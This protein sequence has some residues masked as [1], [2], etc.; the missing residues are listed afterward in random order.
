MRAFGPVRRG[1]APRP[2][3]GAAPAQL[4]GARARATPRRRAPGRWE[5][6][7]LER[8]SKHPRRKIKAFRFRS[9]LGS[10]EKIEAPWSQSYH[11]FIHSRWLETRT[12]TLSLSRAQQHNKQQMASHCVAR[13]PSFAQYRLPA[14]KARRLPTDKWLARTPA[15]RRRRASKAQVDQLAAHTRTPTHTQV[16]ARMSCVVLCREKGKGSGRRRLA[17]DAAALRNNAHTT[18]AR[19]QTSCLASPRLKARRATVRVTLI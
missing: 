12:A 18:F 1:C 7:T 8:A 10:K 4:V 5:E 6:K 19:S 3:A 15:E 13:E 16:G 2:L 9:T 14:W 17:I 11:S